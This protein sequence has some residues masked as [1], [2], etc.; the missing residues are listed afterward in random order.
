[1]SGQID[2]MDTSGQLSLT[3]RYSIVG[4]PLVIHQSDMDPT[5]LECGT[6][7]LVE[8]IEGMYVVY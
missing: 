2:V 6:I 8:E 5:H 3:G 4:R 7:R 1:M